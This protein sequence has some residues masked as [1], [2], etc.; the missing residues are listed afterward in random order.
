MKPMTRTS[1][2]GLA[3]MAAFMAAALWIVMPVLYGR[4][5]SIPLTV[6]VSLWVMTGVCAALAW[7]VAAARKDDA[8]GI[9]L[10]S[11]QLNPLTVANFMLVGRASAWTGAVAGGAYAGMVI[12]LLPK[13]ADVV[14]AQA[15]LPGAALAAV[16]GLGMSVAGVVLERHCEVPPPTDA[17]GAVS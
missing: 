1:V 16:G 4:M 9:G 7:K 8:H 13:V 5:S 17:A 14:A 6:G 12:Y 3:G 15:D 10:D 11:S 2:A